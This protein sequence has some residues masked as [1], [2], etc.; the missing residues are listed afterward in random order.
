M[1][2]LRES[3]ENQ[4]GVAKCTLPGLEP[5]LWGD[6][7]TALEDN[8]HI[9]RSSCEPQGLEASSDRQGAWAGAVLPQILR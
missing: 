4:S 1:P 3:R 5:S 6:A 2:C 7:V 9:A 8:A